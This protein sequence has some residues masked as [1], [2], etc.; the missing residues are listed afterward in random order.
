MKLSFVRKSMFGRLLAVTALMLVAGFAGCALLT[1]PTLPQSRFEGTY[2]MP[3]LEADKPTVAIVLGRDQTEITDVIVPYVAFKLAGAFNV[4]L[5]AEQRRSVALT[6]NLDVLPDFSFAEL[7]ARLEGGPDLI[8]VPNIPDIK[9]NE[10][11]RLWIQQHVQ[12][13][14]MV[15]SICAGAAMLAATGLLDG[16]KATTHWGDILWIER[17]YP[18]VNWVRGQRYVDDGQVISSAGL[19]SGLDA[20][21]HMITRMQGKELALKVARELNHPTQYLEN[22]AMPQHPFGLNDAV[23]VLRFMTPS[24]KPPLGVALFDGVDEMALTALYDTYVPWVAG[25]LVSIAPKGELITTKYGMR[26]LARSSPETWD[27]SSKILLPTPPEDPRR[28]AWLS[29]FSVMPTLAGADQ[30]P[31]APALEY[32]AQHTDKATA[33]FVAK[34]LEYRWFGP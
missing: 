20:S 31:F 3:T 6:G 1:P 32:V 16:K 30:S 7:D 5:V 4:V 9:A 15:M 23:F 2:P 27:S 26:L 11:S 24:S 12:R 8:V 34:R 18:K 25:Q 28:P 21:L 22:P 19:L 13:D 33:D 14:S 17:S 10:A 29:S